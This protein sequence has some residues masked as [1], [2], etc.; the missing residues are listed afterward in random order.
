MLLLEFLPS[1]QTLFDG[2]VHVKFFFH[3]LEV[4]EFTALE[5]FF[6]SVHSVKEGKF[7][8]G[9]PPIQP[10]LF[11]LD[12]DFKQLA[13]L[14]QLLLR[15]FVLFQLFLEDCLVQGSFPSDLLYLHLPALLELLEVLGDYI[16][17]ETDPV[18]L[19]FCRLVVCLQQSSG[20]THL[21]ELALETKDIAPHYFQLIRLQPAIAI[22]A[23]QTF[24]Q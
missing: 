16:A 13:F 8:A 18:Q 3:P 4:G 5:N 12:S 19:V 20:Y 6:V 11:L 7:N 15:L 24:F 21:N 10:Q 9:L 22:D 1:T 23:A 2:G 17:L 14:H